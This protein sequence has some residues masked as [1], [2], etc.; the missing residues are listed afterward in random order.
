MFNIFV[1]ILLNLLCCRT[2]LLPTNLNNHFTKTLYSPGDSLLTQEH[3]CPGLMLNRLLGRRSGLIF[4]VQTRSR[5]RF[6][7]DISTGMWIK[8]DSSKSQ[9]A[10][11]V[12][13]SLQS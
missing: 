2:T 4:Q 7:L 1:E 12:S 11:G 6:L 3:L 9:S 8:H 13:G 10:A 5:Y